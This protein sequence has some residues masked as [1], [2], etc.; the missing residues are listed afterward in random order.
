MDRLY[1]SWI[2]A[3]PLY[4]LIFT[5]ILVECDAVYV[6]PS[7]QNISDN[8]C[9]GAN[10]MTLS[11]VAH[12]RFSENVV[13]LILLSGNHSLSSKLTI[14]GVTTYSMRP[15]KGVSKVVI[16]CGPHSKMEFSNI[17]RVSIRGLI[18]SGC[19][20]I[21]SNTVKHFTLEDSTLLGGHNNIVMPASKG[22][23]IIA[24]RMVILGT[25]FMSFKPGPVFRRG[26]PLEGRSLLYGWNSTVHISNC[27][28]TQNTGGALHVV[29][30]SNLTI[31]SSNFSHHTSES[32]LFCNESVV[33]GN[34]STVIFS[35][36]LFEKNVY[37]EDFT[38]NGGV[39]FASESIVTVIQTNFS[40]NIGG[41][42]YCGNGSIIK[43]SYS[44]F[45]YNRVE[46]NGGVANTRNCTITI[47]DCGFIENAA[48]EHGGVLYVERSSIVL[49][50]SY[51]H[52]NTAVRGGVAYCI[53][54]SFNISNS[55]FTFN[56][57]DI[58]GGSMFFYN[59]SKSKIKSSL[60]SCN[61]A[62]SFGGAL[63]AFKDSK[64]FIDEGTK[65]ESNS[66][67]CGGAIFVHG[68]TE[69]TCS[70]DLS[71]SN[72][73]AELGV[74]GVFRSK[75]S[76]PGSTLFSGNMG[77]LLTFS[78]D[79][80]ISG[81]VMFLRNKQHNW[82]TET[83]NSFLNTQEGGA[84]TLLLSKLDITGMINLSKNCAHNGG[85]ILAMTSYIIQRG[86][87]WIMN[88][89]ATGTGGGFY[90]YQSVVFVQGATMIS[91]NKADD[92][93]G[94]IH[95]VSSTIICAADSTFSNN[96]YVQ[97]NR[98]K[99][100][101]GACLE[102]YS[103]FHF[104]PWIRLKNLRLNTLVKFIHNTAEYYGGAVYVADNTS[105]GTCLSGVVK[106]VTSISQSEC[107]F[108]V[109]KIRTVPYTL[110]QVFYFEGNHATISGAQLFGGLLDR[111]TV[112][113][114]QK[115]HT[116]Y[117]ITS[118]FTDNFLDHTSS[119]PV[120][121]CLCYRNDSLSTIMCGQKSDPEKVVKGETFSINIAAVD[122]VNHMIN[123]TVNAYLSDKNSRLAHGQYTR[124][125]SAICT[126]LQFSITSTHD[127]EEL[128][129][130]A[131]GPCSDLGISLLKLRIEF[132]PC[133]CPIGFEETKMVRD[134]C[135]C[136][137]HNKLLQLPFINE[138]NCD[139]NTLRIMRTSDF[140]ISTA[141]LSFV[142]AEECPLLYCVPF[143][144]Q[145]SINLD[146]P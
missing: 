30:N 88:N 126:E 11:Q 47:N 136:T 120:R 133:Y 34:R 102:V 18:L 96:F 106:T 83:S 89:T 104:T 27:S 144:T 63:S 139:S 54:S 129:L 84:I 67:Y 97:N 56:K 39:I 141:N 86:E 116:Q 105:I 140:W 103:K 118:N 115:H 60:F 46:K 77:S 131:Q 28:F 62:H 21:V 45:K 10:C 61:S 145:V 99:Y 82:D 12:T 92:Y 57:A 117:S 111:C 107:F 8:R 33:F 95:A 15:A 35:C 2:C 127:Y 40:N 6:S 81:S 143:M 94:G 20:R 74:F 5:S 36:S 98:A 122:Q 48:E 109:T 134:R 90:L 69:I 142:S 112:K 66:A 22:L 9:S 71:I 119:D 41:V 138:S 101:G 137:C 1:F 16:N 64:V 49:N 68:S 128:F 72:N 23:L 29:N 52:H 110:E 14:C 42:M 24:S 58:T 100:G 123:A 7:L 3:L 38:I 43:L 44:N 51:F 73:T 91:G 70:G 65:F 87:I 79:I 59:Y 50:H 113:A 108:Q 17:A 25:S 93:G 26:D 32:V 53:N 121:V 124:H 13:N 114:F 130:Y 37:H 4:M 125:V 76:F 132:I 78:G 55:N 31:L 19:V 135:V 85:G 80:S 75:A 146:S